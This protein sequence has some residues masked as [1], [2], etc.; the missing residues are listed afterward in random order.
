MESKVM[1]YGGLLPL[2]DEIRE[3]SNNGII[4]AVCE[5]AYV[6]NSQEWHYIIYKH[7]IPYTHRCPICSHRKEGKRY[8][9]NCICIPFACWHHGGH[10][11]CHCNTHV[12]NDSNWNRIAELD[13]NA[14]LE[15]ARK[16]IGVRDIMLIRGD[17]VMDSLRRGDVCAHF[18]GGKY[19]HTSLYLGEGKMLDCSRKITHITIRDAMETEYAIRYTGGHDHLAAGD[20]GSA[21]GKV[22]EFLN[23]YFSDCED[24]IPLET[25]GQF[26]CCTQEAVMRFQLHK[27]LESDGIIGS[28][29][30]ASMHSCGQKL[31]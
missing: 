20:S 18:S 6:L 31:T 8:G 19:V 4:D 5:Y 21:V 25:D 30:L 2:A 17:S 15:I 10:I 7:F 24:W 13:H 1:P 29:T 23:W 14:A 12:I 3:A 26:G 11:P 27:C 16:R 9:S 22:Q 28:K